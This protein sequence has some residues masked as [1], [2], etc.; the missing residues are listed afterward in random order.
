MRLFDSV[1]FHRS[2][3][4]IRFEIRKLIKKHPLFS[5]VKL[6][7]N[8]IDWKKTKEFW[9]EHSRVAD[10]LFYHERL[11]DSCLTLSALYHFQDL[12]LATFQLTVK[13]FL[14]RLEH[15]VKPRYS[16]E[17]KKLKEDV[18]AQFFKFDARSMN[19]LPSYY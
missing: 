18:L 13:K 3:K 6:F 7:L 9:E 12:Y 10:R 8:I 15:I 17:V 11:S 5:D 2:K 19:Y 14:K 4:A 16:G 1:A